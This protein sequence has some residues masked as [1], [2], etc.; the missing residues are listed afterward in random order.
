MIAAASGRPAAS[1]VVLPDGI[2]GLVDA[3][4]A[5]FA[6]VPVWTVDAVAVP[7]WNLRDVLDSFLARASKQPCRRLGAG[8]L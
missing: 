8:Q 6:A 4:R 7:V 2:A 1:A 5:C 3:L